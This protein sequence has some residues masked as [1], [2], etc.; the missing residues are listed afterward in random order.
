MLVLSFVF[1]FIDFKGVSRV[2]FY[3]SLVFLEFFVIDSLRDSFFVISLFVGCR[4]R[5]RI[6]IFFRGRERG[7][8]RRGRVY[9]GVCLVFFFLKRRF[10]GSVWGGGCVLLLEENDEDFF[11]K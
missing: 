8:R 2:F 3:G 5:F 9:L 7:Y 6:V 11:L 4:W 10:L 1:Y